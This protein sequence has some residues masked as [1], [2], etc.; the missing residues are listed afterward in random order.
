MHKTIPSLHVL[1]FRN[2]GHKNPIKSH[3]SKINNNTKI[4]TEIID[5]IMYQFTLIR[6]FTQFSTSQLLYTIRQ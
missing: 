2:K 1:K 6:F 4:V 3:K 5:T